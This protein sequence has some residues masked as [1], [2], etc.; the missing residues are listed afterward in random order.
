MI[1]NRDAAPPPVTAPTRRTMPHLPPT[2]AVVAFGL[3][4]AAGSTPMPGN[5][6]RT[7]PVRPHLWAVQAE[8]ADSGRHAAFDSDREPLPCNG[9]T[10][11]VVSP[12]HLRHHRIFG[13]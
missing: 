1:T 6:Q 11:S 8:H 5:G 7:M 3:R 13:T 10:P 12:H 2:V 4:R 9:F